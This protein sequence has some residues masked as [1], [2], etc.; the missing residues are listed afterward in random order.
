MTHLS[1]KPTLK[2]TNMCNLDTQSGNSR[3]RIKRYTASI[4]LILVLLM[5]AANA[6]SVADDSQAP[7]NKACLR[8]HA[9]A[10]LAYR[11]PGT[12]DL[13]H[14]AVNPQALSH[15]VHGELAC[16]ECHEGDLDLYPH[17]SDRI[18]ETLSCVGCHEARDDAEKRVYRFKTIDAEYARSVHATSDSVEV[19]GFSC[20]SCHDPHRFRA[21]KVGEEIASIVHD[22]NQV[23][24]SCHEKV[25]DPASDPHAWLP[26]REK[27]W[28]A[29]RCIDC[30]TP[31]SDT[32]QAVSHQ[33]LK[34]EDSNHDCVNCHS[35][36]PRLLNRLYQYRSA[37][38]LARKGWLNK[39]VFNDAYVVGMSRNPALD[40]FGLIVIGLTLLVL[41][42]HGVGRYKAYQ[43]SRGIKS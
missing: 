38:D 18:G 4:R 13:V 10:T 35:R 9:M 42:A 28:N 39:A 5:V 34:A 25:R 37:E 23:C 36:E 12:G 17:P 3:R 6:I 2:P 33:I 41:A 1:A 43:R 24:L 29:V 15:S 31:L 27:H 40:L 14:L 21:S 30:H 8:C 32:G 19:N 16:A 20:H 26:N 11:D 7:D 22:D